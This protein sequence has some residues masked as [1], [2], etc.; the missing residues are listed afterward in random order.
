[1]HLHSHLH[2]ISFPFFFIS[3]LFV[4]FLF[5]SSLLLSV[6]ARYARL[7]VHVYIDGDSADVHWLCYAVPYQLSVISI[8]IISAD[9]NSSGERGPEEDR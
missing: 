3:A 2:S 1:M 7:D 8:G 6:L 4:V 5:F 9:M